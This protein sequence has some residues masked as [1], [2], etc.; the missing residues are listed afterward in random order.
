MIKLFSLLLCSLNIIFSNSINC[1]TPIDVKNKG[2]ISYETK[3]YDINNYIHPGGQETLF[4]SK[5]KPLEQ[6]FNMPAY[7][8]HTLPSS[9]TKNDLVNFYIGDLYNSCGNNNTTQ[10][11][12][13]KPNQNIKISIYNP[14]VLF[15]SISICFAFLYTIITY[16]FT[17]CKE[18]LLLNEPINLHYFNFISKNNLIFSI[19]YF[20][21][22]LSLLIFSM[23]YKNNLYSLGV[24]I[25]LNLAVTL[26]PMT[27]NSIWVNIFNIQYN[28]LIYNH[29]LMGVLAFLS[30]VIKI[31]VSIIKYDFNFLFSR[32]STT[33]GTISSIFVILLVMLSIS[34]VRKNI[35]E[36]FYYSHRILTVLIIVTMSFHYITCIFYVVP[37]L[38]LYIIDLICRWI[39]INKSIYTKINNFYFNDLSSHYILLT[40]KMKKKINIKPGSYFFICCTNISKFQWHPISLL[41]SENN[42][43]TFCIK[44]MGKKSWSNKLKNFKNNML[45]EELEI[46]LQGPYSHFKLNYK[47]NNYKYIFNISNGIGITP[48]FSILDDI[49][50]MYLK[51]ELTNL[52]KVIFIWVIPNELFLEPFITRLQTI[53]H[54]IINI[55]IYITKP[56]SIHDINE[57]YYQI[58]DIMNCKPN[59]SCYIE[60]FIICNNWFNW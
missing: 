22:W 35:F 50:K 42:T 32:F 41:S 12:P 47:N 53:N 54:D 16:S 39:H 1:Y 4:L 49:N 57:S 51:K 18:S 60:K 37:A 59:I 14:H 30:V 21:W 33:M 20:T 40:L 2:F 7:Q 24:W 6:F 11:L 10:Y 58:F 34:F 43:L 13:S 36:L 56:T 19:F 27:R 44:D 15:S 45:N 38:T 26:L 29:K 25:C 46:Y 8:F 23:F 9:M 17:F 31:I 5:G 48:F 55:M 3:V 52:K 28:N